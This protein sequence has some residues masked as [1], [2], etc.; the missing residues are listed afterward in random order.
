MLYFGVSCGEV[1]K[2]LV[3]EGVVKNSVWDVL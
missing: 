3:H 1:D 2:E